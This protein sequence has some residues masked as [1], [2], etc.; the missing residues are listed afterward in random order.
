MSYDSSSQRRY[1]T[2]EDDLRPPLRGNDY[3]NNSYRE[4]RESQYLIVPAGGH[5]RA[6][7]TSRTIPV[8][9]IDVAP[10]RQSSGSL[11]NSYY[12]RRS[13]TLDVPSRT[14]TNRTRSPSP[15]PGT[16]SK[17][18]QLTP[19]QSPPS[20][21]TTSLS[22]KVTGFRYKPLNPGNEK[23]IRV[24]HVHPDLSRDGHVCC[25]LSHSSISA[26]Y[27][28]LSYTWSSTPS[29]SSRDKNSKSS[30]EDEATKTIILNDKPFPVRSN[31]HSF[32]KSYAR[33]SLADRPLWVD[34]I[35]INQEDV[36][37]KNRQVGMM[38]KI[39]SFTKEVLV[40]L[41]P[42]ES[43]GGY[44]GHAIKRMKEYADMGDIE[45][46]METARDGDFWKGFRDVNSA[47]YWDRVWV[48]KCCHFI[49]I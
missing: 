31:L 8:Y 13:S 1:S 5:R 25:D 14:T 22:R 9:E 41:G 19:P 11:S 4:V 34:A 27:S 45:V 42:E 26:E 10:P 2:R 46:A 16:R 48:S 29:A 40:W 47:F 23:S 37:E 32:L 20:S 44:A 24:L 15:G 6:N 35:C 21:N 3:Y 30:G 39:Y 28:A 7:S 43:K 49:L 17:S 36:E 12:E 38:W 18:R 33:R